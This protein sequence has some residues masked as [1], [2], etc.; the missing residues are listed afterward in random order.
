MSQFYQ[1]FVLTLIPILQNTTCWTRFHPLISPRLL[2]LPLKKK[3]IRNLKNAT[4]FKK[5]LFIVDISLQSL[6]N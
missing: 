3:C 6:I 4:L 2:F 5:T 1:L